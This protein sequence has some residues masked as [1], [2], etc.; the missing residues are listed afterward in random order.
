M[1][2]L[3]VSQLVKQNHKANQCYYMPKKSVIPSLREI[4]KPFGKH[5]EHWIH[6]TKDKTWNGEKEI[7][8]FSG[9]Y[10]ILICFTFS[11]S[12]V[13]HSLSGLFNFT[14][15]ICHDFSASVSTL[16]FLPYN[17]LSSS[18]GLQQQFSNKILISWWWGTSN[19][20]WK[21]LFAVYNMESIVKM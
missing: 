1:W 11:N 8:S 15:K 17:R 5:I 4:S 10:S 20:S 9:G 7:S 21:Q 12:F 2:C 6:G 14:A 19:Y 18:P 13:N 16:L 3:E